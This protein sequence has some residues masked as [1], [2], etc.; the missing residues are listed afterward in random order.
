M[1]CKI[2]TNEIDEHDLRGLPAPHRERLLSVG[3]CDYCDRWIENWQMR[4]D[5][6]VARIGYQHYIIGPAH[7]KTK[8]MGG[9]RSAI[10]FDDGRLVLTDNLW[11]QG[12]IPIAFAEALPNNARFVS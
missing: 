1:T 9:H 3:V 8:G 12:R 5:P 11:H 6:K 2:C 4:D 7:Q 10:Q